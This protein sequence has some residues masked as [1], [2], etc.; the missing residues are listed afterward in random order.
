LTALTVDAVDIII[1]TVISRRQFNDVQIMIG[2]SIADND[3]GGN[4]IILLLI[5]NKPNPNMGNRAR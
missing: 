3:S 2:T 5:P 1:V 4:S